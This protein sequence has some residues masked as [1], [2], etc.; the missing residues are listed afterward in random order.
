MFERFTNRARRVLVLAQEEARLLGH[1]FLGTEHILLGILHEGEGSGGRALESLGVPLVVVR[2]K[3]AEVIG[4]S[5]G[6]VTGSPPFTPRAKKVL[7][8]SLRETLA[9]G[10]KDI[11]TG[12]LLLGIIEEGEGVGAQ[13]LAQIG[14]DAGRLR[15]EVLAILPGDE[16][17]VGESP[18]AP[19]PWAAPVCG[20]C[21]SPLAGSA[22]YRS[23]EAAAGPGEDDEGPKSITVFCCARCGSPFGSLGSQAPPGP[24]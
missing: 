18:A 23:I 2:S 24:S 19:E 8:L 7:E 4:P 14:I 22:L 12:H 3:V 20:R 9:L 10:H 11:A 16:G 17:A 6:S 13:V 15:R 1:G 21:G 5:G